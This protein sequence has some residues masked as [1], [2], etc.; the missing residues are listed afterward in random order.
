MALVR[1]QPFREVES[2][3]RQMNRLFDQLMVPDDEGSIMGSGMKFMP[4]AE[5]HE[6]PDEI[7][8]RIE[9]PGIEASDLDVNVSTE[10]V[11]ISGDRKSEIKH[12]DKGMSRS[13]FRYGRFQRII[14][15]PTRIQN[16]KVQAEFKN[17]VLCVTLPKAEEEK[18][19]VVKVNLNGQSQQG[20]Q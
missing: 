5:M 18:N 19:K 1:L 2:L 11:S 7:K 9:V 14:P 6:T 13:E 10:A 20:E 8:L 17:G 3:Q 12:E 15:L 4:A 16:D